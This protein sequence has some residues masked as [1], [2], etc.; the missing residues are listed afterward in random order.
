MYDTGSARVANDLLWHAWSERLRERGLIGPDSVALERS[1][2]AEDVWRDPNLLL[3]QACSLPW[4]LGL[5]RVCRIFALPCYSAP[6]CESETYRSAIVARADAAGESLADFDGATVAVNGVR[7]HS[8]HTSLVWALGM[9]GLPMPFFSRAKVSGTHAESLRMVAE[10]RA[11]LAAID[12]VTLAIQEADRNTHLDGLRRLSWTPPAP[13]L[14]LITSANR[15][16]SLDD[17][18]YETLVEALS[19]EANRSVRDTLFLELPVRLEREHQAEF[20]TVRGAWRRARDV[21]IAHCWEGAS[22]S[23]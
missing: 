11:D 10:G 6:G 20:D 3:A 16:P 5:E 2:S 23:D 15:E 18:L 19:D 4:A 8:G 1:R 9:E 14:P 22:V 12:C 21:G 13:S 7:S 17:Q